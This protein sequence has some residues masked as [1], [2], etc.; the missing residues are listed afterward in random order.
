MKKFRASM[1]PFWDLKVDEVCRVTN[2]YIQRVHK[3]HATLSDKYGW[4]NFLPYV[5]PYYKYS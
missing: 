3:L 5:I 2:A 4:S 1:E